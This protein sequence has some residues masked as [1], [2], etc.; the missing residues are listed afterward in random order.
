MEVMNEYEATV[1][2]LTHYN[3][4]YDYNYKQ[5]YQYDWLCKHNCNNFDIINYRQSLIVK[6]CHNNDLI[7]QYNAK[8][9]KH[10]NISNLFQR[11]YFFLH[12]YLK[13]F[14]IYK[15]KQNQKT[16]LKRN[17]LH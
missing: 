7:N 17:Y 14:T 9:E 11:I 13:P 12:F 3:T 16:Y 8:I 6:I 2:K 15:N 4:V 10:I 1:N 5:T